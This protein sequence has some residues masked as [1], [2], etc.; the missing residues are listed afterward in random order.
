[1]RNTWMVEMPFASIFEHP[2]VG[3]MATVLERILTAELENTSGDP[4][5]STD[6]HVSSATT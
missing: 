1:V 6:G 3:G 4:D 2:T 5:A